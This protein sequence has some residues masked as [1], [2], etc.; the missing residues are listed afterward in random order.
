MEKAASVLSEV[1]FFVASLR[2]R[3]CGASETEERRLFAAASWV[4]LVEWSDHV[5]FSSNAGSD[6]AIFIRNDTFSACADTHGQF[7]CML[8]R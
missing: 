1:G 7:L 8:A 3:E 6:L 2:L 4:F 5:R